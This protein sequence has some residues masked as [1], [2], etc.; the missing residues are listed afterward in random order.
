MVNHRLLFPWASLLQAPLFCGMSDILPFLSVWLNETLRLKFDHGHMRPLK[1]KCWIAA[2]G[3][4]SKKDLT[5]GVY[6]IFQSGVLDRPS[7]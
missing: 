4:A 3:I 1:T 5:F 7:G 6:S 2:L